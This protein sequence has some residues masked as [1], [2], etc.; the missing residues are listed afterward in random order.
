MKE[1]RNALNVIILVIL[2]GTIVY[3]V[4][5][6]ISTNKRMTNLQNK[7]DENNIS[8]NN[9][10]NEQNYIIESINDFESILKDIQHKVTDSM[11]ITI[12]VPEDL[13]A[14]HKL[15]W[16]YYFETL[17]SLHSIEF[18]KKDIVTKR[19]EDKIKA[20]A[21]EAAKYIHPLHGPKYASIIYFKVYEKTAYC[22]LDISCDGYMRVSYDLRKIEPLI[23]KTLLQFIEI[24]NVVFSD[25]APGD[26][27]EEI[28]D[29]YFEQ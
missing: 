17:D 26:D 6:N 14:Y 22:L 10:K 3:L 13:E 2:L 20:S 16:D 11:T 25:V 12:V 4:L 21:D 24:E 29:K 27:F 19:Q 5:N 7:I 28:V 23:E 8:T 9:I 15:D 18:I 1:K